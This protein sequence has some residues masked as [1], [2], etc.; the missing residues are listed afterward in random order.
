MENTKVFAEMTKAEKFGAIQLV[1]GI[2]DEMKE[3]LNKEIESL[4]KKNSYKSKADKKKDAEN[5]EIENIIVEMVNTF[6]TPSS[7]ADIALMVGTKLDKYIST[8]RITPR[9]ASLVKENRIALVV[10]KGVNKYKAV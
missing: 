10:E 7:T 3:F 9:C 6:E 5:V 4:K 8:Q 2:T 1:S